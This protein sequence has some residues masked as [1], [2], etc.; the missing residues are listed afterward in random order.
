MLQQENKNYLK[1]LP[2]YL[3]VVFSII[4]LYIEF[5]EYWTP[6]GGEASLQL[7]KFEIPFLL[8]LS[9]MLFFPKI[10]IKT[11]KY[12][13]PAI[14]ILI[15][16][17]FFDNFYGFLERS[18]RPS[19]FQNFYTI[20]DFS[21]EMV[22]WIILFSLFIP[23]AIILLIYQDNKNCSPKAII[24]SLSY[25]LFFLLTTVAIL[26]SDT[27]IKYH[28]KTYTYIN[29]SQERT[30][31]ENGR[32]SSFIFYGHQE[33]Q[34]F[35]TLKKYMS[36]DINIQSILYPGPIANPKNIHIIV[37]ESFID[38]RLINGLQFNKSPLA[39]ELLPHL[40]KK[41]SFSHVIS[42]AYGGGTA[43]VEFELL[44]GIKALAKIDSIE[45]NVM[46][47]EKMSSFVDHLNQNGYKSIATIATGAG[48]FNSTQ[49][50]KSLGFDEVSFLE[51]SKNFKKRKGDAKIFD[52]DLL[53]H[54]IEKIKKSVQNENTPLFNY[55]LGMYGHFP[56]KRN[57]SERPDIIEVSHEDNRIK[58]ISNQFFYRTKAIAKYINQ[59]HSIDPN[60]IIYI[61]SDH[62]PPLF[63]DEIN[64]QLDKHINISLFIKGKVSINV[65]GKRH[66][67][68]PW[69]IW[70]SLTGTEHK[71]PLQDDKMEELYFK[72]LSESV[73]L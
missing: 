51:E 28:T 72:A 8:T 52:G 39:V 54:N 69:L 57:I 29:W 40:Y 11:V 58:K 67:E 53:D 64:Y 20:F 42:P 14:P 49:A 38:P 59:L 1:T 21:P 3:L 73:H 18:P 34:N 22:F 13:V 9:I 32:F 10:K 12:V 62:L 35:L 36:S 56:Y 37:L 16:Y 6:I 46:N 24:C 65:S 17:A 45:F 68:I 2:I 70:D 44:T 50:Y 55:V 47:G 30:I 19:D 15:I 23:I 66:F 5:S 33:K 71:R 60:S 61:T 41:N 7:F 31:R 63:G 48:Y 25:R 27:F 26:S 43:Q 4:G